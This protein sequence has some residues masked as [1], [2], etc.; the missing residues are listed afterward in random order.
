MLH[1]KGTYPWTPVLRFCLALFGLLLAPPVSGP[2]AQAQDAAAMFD[3]VIQGGLVYDGSLSEPRQADIGVRGDTIAAVG[4]L[5]QSSATHRIDA[6]G[7]A[8]T[9]GF[10]NMLSW[11]S[12]SLIHDGR[13]QSDIRQ[14]VTLEV[15]GEGWSMGPLNTSM[16]RDKLRGLSA[17][18]YEVNWTTLA[19]YLD[20]LVERGVSP[21]VASLVGATTVRIHVLGYANRA[22]QL[23]RA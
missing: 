15:F 20:R 9:P 17:A 2:A 18:K 4:D 12:E 14:G 1:L 16:K 13:S 23:R 22:A 7:M 19:E 3:V 21:N 10:I 11:A 5:S 6:R 8:V